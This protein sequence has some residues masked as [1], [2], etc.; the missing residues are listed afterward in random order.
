MDAVTQVTIAISQKKK[1]DSHN[2]LFSNGGNYAIMLLSIIGGIIP[3]AQ[4]ETKNLKIN[5][6]REVKPR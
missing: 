4:P 6:L 2:I 1:P 3:P 5:Q